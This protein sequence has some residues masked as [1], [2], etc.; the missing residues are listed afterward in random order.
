MHSYFYSSKN[1]TRGKN[2]SYH[3][4]IFRALG[5]A[6]NNKNPQETFKGCLVEVGGNGKGSGVGEVVGGSVVI[7]ASGVS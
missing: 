1:Y 3:G 4:S 7:Y 5:C 6:V 2:S